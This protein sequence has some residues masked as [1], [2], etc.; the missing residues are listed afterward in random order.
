[1]NCAI[2][3]S[4]L[5]EDIRVCPICRVPISSTEP[6]NATKKFRPSLPKRVLVPVF[7]AV[8]VIVTVSLVQY[9]II[10]A[11]PYSEQLWAF[12]QKMHAMQQP[13][14]VTF[15]IRDQEGKPANRFR[16]KA[17]LASVPWYYRLLP[18]TGI[19]SSCHVIETDQRGQATLHP[20]IGRAFNLRMRQIDV[21]QYECPHGT[22][23]KPNIDDEY[24]FDSTNKGRLDISMQVLRHGPPVKL[25]TMYVKYP[26]RPDAFI[27]PLQDEQAFGFHFQNHRGFEGHENGELLITIRNAAQ[28][29]QAYWRQHGI[30]DIKKWTEHPTWM[31]QLDGKDRYLLKKKAPGYLTYAPLDGY[32]QV[33]EFELPISNGGS[34]YFEQGVYAI[35]KEPRR[36]LL[37]RVR[38]T[39]YSTSELLTSIQGFQNTSGDPNLYEA[40]HIDESTLEKNLRS[41]E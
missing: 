15:R 33:L 20:K 37:F 22:D 7:V 5:A 8:L 35:S 3:G 30:E 31:I 24:Y 40:P 28:A 14:N 16:F 34:A 39:L 29:A 17:V 11:N 1:M 27:T 2:C 25:E 26:V 10:G 4:S 23:T 18:L 21:S 9:A 41:C 6:V 12:E 13:V 36:Y 38:V 19:S 32:Q